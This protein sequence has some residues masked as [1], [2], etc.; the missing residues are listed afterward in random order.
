M[1][2]CVARWGQGKSAPN[3]PHTEEVTSANFKHFSKDGYSFTVG[4]LD[5]IVAYELI[6]KE[7]PNKLTDNDVVAI[8]HADSA[9]QDWNFVKSAPSNSNNW[10]RT[11][12][13]YA[14]YHPNFSYVILMSKDFYETWYSSTNQHPF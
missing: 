3:P 14:T 5:G 10:V 8:L 11:D 1:D 7:N 2:Q 13:A 9:N 12:G 4:F 6:G